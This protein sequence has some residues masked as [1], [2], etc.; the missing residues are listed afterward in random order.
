MSVF[1][2]TTSGIPCPVSSYSLAQSLHSQIMDDFIQTFKILRDMKGKYGDV[3][4][5]GRV[6]GG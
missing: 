1:F 6:K 5:H 2:T 3:F 4:A